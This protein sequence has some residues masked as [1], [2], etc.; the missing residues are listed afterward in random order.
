M[1]LLLQEYHPALLRA[2]IAQGQIQHIKSAWKHSL[3]AAQTRL[4]QQGPALY[5]LFARALAL[6]KLPKLVVRNLAEWKQALSAQP[7]VDKAK[8][9]AFTLP[10]AQMYATVMEALLLVEDHVGALAAY[11]ELCTKVPVQM[12]FAPDVMTIVMQTLMANGDQ[13]VSRAS[14]LWSR[15]A[16]SLQ[17]LT[18]PVVATFVSWLAPI[19]AARRNQH[20]TGPSG[21]AQRSAGSGDAGASTAHS[22]ATIEAASSC[23]ASVVALLKSSEV[24]A[25]VASRETYEL[26]YRTLVPSADSHIIRHLDQARGLAGLSHSADTA[27]LCLQAAYRLKEYAQAQTM[28][29]LL[30]SMDAPATTEEFEWTMRAAVQANKMAD[31]LALHEEMRKLGLQPSLAVYSLMISTLASQVE[32]KVAGPVIKELFAQLKSHQWAVTAE[33]IQFFADLVE[34]LQRVGAKKLAVEAEKYYIL[35]SAMS[36]GDPV[37][38]VHLNTV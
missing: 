20:S 32:K 16:A 28:H 5:A 26:L 9:K 25:A 6:A 7:R 10:T 35:T 18:Q 31:L 24:A 4:F 37:D 30:R 36:E 38:L 27:M 2:L 15:A 8:V 19:A 3:T 23:L 13:G 33:L 11:D 22:A 34:P 1:V 21:P 12:S 29:G 17:H 14:R